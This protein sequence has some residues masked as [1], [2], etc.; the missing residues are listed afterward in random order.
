VRIAFA[1]KRWSSFGDRR[2][3]MKLLR[4]ELIS[5]TI[6]DRENFGGARQCFIRCPILNS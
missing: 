3:S 2:D 6:F 4:N 5:Q 1:G